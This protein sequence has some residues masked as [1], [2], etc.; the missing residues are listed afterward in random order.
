[1]QKENNIVEQAWILLH[2]GHIREVVNL[3][4]PL[5]EE[6]EECRSEREELLHLHHVMGVAL[7]YTNEI[8]RA[9]TCFWQMRKLAQQRGDG[10]QQQIAWSYLAEMSRRQNA[11]AQALSHFN[12]ALAIPPIDAAAQGLCVLFYARLF[13]WHNAEKSARHLLS[14]AEQ[15][16]EE[17]DP[18]HNSTCGQFQRGRV[19][20]EHAF[21]A[22]ISGR[23]EEILFS[24]RQ[25][26]EALAG[27]DLWKPYLLATRGAALVSKDALREGVP[28]VLEAARLAKEQGNTQI[29]GRLKE[30]ERHLGHK[31][32]EYLHAT[33]ALS[34]VMDGSLGG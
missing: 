14:K 21:Y 6:K 30:V 10:V 4:Q 25:A 19:F 29:V 17:V 13:L 1:M 23:V 31:A 24:C 22:S 33:S 26:E 11:E 15:W 27:M 28:M 16:A 7:T 18:Q 20:L 34:E 3:V 2:A 32:Q 9:S 12:A 5:L 8:R